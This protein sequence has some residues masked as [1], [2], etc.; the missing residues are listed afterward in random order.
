MRSSLSVLL[1]ASFFAC[2]G[3]AF[4]AAE[5]GDGGSGDA[6]ETD[7]AQS[8]DDASGDDGAIGD[9]GTIDASGDA[10]ASN[11][12][13]AMDSAR[14]DSA[15]TYD[16]GVKLFEIDPN[17]THFSATYCG[18][19]QP[20][21]TCGFVYK[22]SASSTNVITAIEVKNSFHG[23]GSNM[24]FLILDGSA[25]T[26]YISASKAYVATGDTWKRS[27][28]FFFTLQAGQQYFIGAIADQPTD[29]DYSGYTT[30]TTQS[31]IS[32]MLVDDVLTNFATPTVG[33]GGNV[34]GLIRLYQ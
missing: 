22:F 10:P 18:V 12:S 14:V 30:T 17:Y 32:S 33:A 16:G 20:Y 26:L 19:G 13:A 25:T 4:T 29:W 28:P 31:G 27:D 8:H 23:S 2:G 24:R 34:D 15:P 5:L 7:S 3:D 21:Y 1:I 11:D 9:A 6:R